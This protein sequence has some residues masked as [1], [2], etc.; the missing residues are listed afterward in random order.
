MW[1]AKFR[2]RARD[3]ER[4]ATTLTFWLSRA[5]VIRLV[6][7]QEAP[8]CRVWGALA[9]RGERGVNRVRFTGR[10]GGELLPAG[11]YRV[12]AEALRRGAVRPLGAVT[13]VIVA[14][15]EPIAKARAQPTT[16]A[17]EIARVTDE[18]I[19]AASSPAGRSSPSGKAK[20][21]GEVASA[22][23]SADEAATALVRRRPLD[24]EGA[25][26]IG[27]LPNPFR[28]APLWLQPFLL[29][30][31]GV[32]IILLQLAALPARVVPSTGAALF[33]SRHRPELALGGMGLLGA[34]AVAAILL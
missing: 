1:P 8:V 23:A 21:G 25:S 30:M 6:V 13:L 16:C 10:V 4:A 27:S 26:V 34:V 17:A 11:T 22:T 15:S 29:G 12:R 19:A 5:G 14:P 20:T 9:V 18:E 24:D 33:V 32:A 28:A 2:N 7:R 3:R 31:L